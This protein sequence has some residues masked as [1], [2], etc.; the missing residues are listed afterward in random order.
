[1][2]PLSLAI[3]GLSAVYLGI[4]GASDLSKVALKFDSH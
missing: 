1:M 4:L 2:L 3:D